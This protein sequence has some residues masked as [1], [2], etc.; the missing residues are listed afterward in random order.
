MIRPLYDT[1]TAAEMLNLLAGGSATGSRDLV[2]AS[3]METAGSNMDQ[4]W[5]DTL[6]AGVVANSAAAPVMATPAKPAFPAPRAGN[7]GM[8]L[9]LSPSPTVWDGRFA[10]NAWLQ[11][12]P[13]PFTKEVWGN[14]VEISTEDAAKLRIQNADEIVLRRGSKEVHAIAAVSA[15]QAPGTVNAL[16]GLRSLARGANRI[17]GGRPHCRANRHGT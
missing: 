5:P 8:A 12:C 17:G 16:F 7:T 9:L 1:R 14:A 11:E 10:N 2:R 13:S 3:W 4:W 15:G 6:T